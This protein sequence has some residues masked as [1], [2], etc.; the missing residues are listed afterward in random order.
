MEQWITS[1]IALIGTAIGS[2]SGV[3]ASN[4]LVNW[5]IRSLEEKVDQHNHLIE[6]MYQVEARSKSNSHRIDELEGRM[7]A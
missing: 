7:S 4:R 6:R 1:I 3:I 2:V 5:R